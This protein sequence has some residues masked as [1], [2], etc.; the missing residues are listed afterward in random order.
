M[1][2]VLA[3]RPAAP[4]RVLARRFGR[5]IG[6]LAAGLGVL[7]WFV[8]FVGSWVPSFWG[9]EAASVMSAER[10]IATLWSELGRVDAVHG[11]YYLFLHFWIDLFGASELS[12]RFPSTVA[13]GV[14]VAG[15]VVLGNLL[16]R[17]RVA[18]VAGIV[19]LVLPRISY[20]A[21]E[22]RSYA[23]GTA[24]AV[25]LTILFVTLL[26][27]RVTTLLPWLA[28]GLVVAASI[29]VFFYFVLI[30][31][32]HG[33]AVLAS[34]ARRSI[35]RRW[36]AAMVVTVI[37]AAPILIYGLAQ[38]GQITFL[39]H[40]G[41][42]TFDRIVIVQWF[43]DLWL[44]TAGWALIIVGIVSL[45]RSRSE[46]RVLLIA[47]LVLPTAALLIGNTVIAPMYTVRYL[48]FCAPIAALMV[49]VGIEA[50][51]ARLA[52]LRRSRMQP[53]L[54]TAI[55]AVLVVA[56]AALAAHT[57]IQQRTPFAKDG[58][59][60]LRQ[61][62]EV[63]AANAHAG[64][65]VVFDETTR[66]S[67]APRLAMRLYPTAFAG[68]TDATLVAKFTEL[69]GLWDKAAPVSDVGGALASTGTVWDLE[70][71]G[72]GTPANIIQLQR[73]GFAVIRTI[74]VHRTVVY[75][76]TRETP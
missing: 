41:Y 29:Y 60:D 76:L 5:G 61:V 24:I 3:E 66:P 59:S 36:L 67:R 48:S 15:I 26:R 53:L 28:Y 45:I 49:A 25:W 40:R 57:D 33:V 63:V 51:G 18:V 32:V 70:L 19:C 34:P 7:G 14:A 44:A 4:G 30:A 56:L 37:A 42:A 75:E 2:N 54:R 20:M 23:I 52:T 58:G 27:R 12:V 21:A 69:P 8:N 38:H 17:R 62:S 6:P 71:K 68:L 43:G 1:S 65:A 46:F 10:P 13:V 9:D 72:S 55:P 64:D 74:P 39:A 35:L 22:G 16:F 11:A 50:V 31:L 73:L 47:W